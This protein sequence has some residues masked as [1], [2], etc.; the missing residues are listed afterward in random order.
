VALLVQTAQ[1]RSEGT[2]VAR[3][4]A[5]RRLVELEL[6]VRFVDCVVGQMHEQIGKVLLFRKTVG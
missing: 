3:V 1:D 6:R 2:L 5:L 4:H